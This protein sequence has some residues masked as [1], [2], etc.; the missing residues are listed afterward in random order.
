MRPSFLRTAL[1]GL[2]LAGASAHAQRIAFVDTKY[3]LGQMPDYAA[4]QQELDRTSKKWQDEIDERW[5]Q[6]KRMREAYNAEAIL[7][8]DEMKKSRQAEI[9]KKEQEARDLQQ[10]RFGVGGD[11]FKKRQELIQ[12][13][14]DR[15]YDAVK[16]VAGSSYV[17]IF[18]IGGVGNN[19]LFASEK[20]DKSDNV[21]RKLGIR[22]GQDGKN[23]GNLRGGEEEN[24]QHEEQD[25]KQDD[26]MRT[27]NKGGADRISPDR[28]NQGRDNI[29]T[30]P[31]Q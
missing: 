29:N 23:A 28:M 9:D 13:I 27:P 24:D 17:A 26:R 5:A 3:I 1:M 10:K 18:D 20:Y 30:K 25:M 8:T 12:P 31:K 11:L 4:A 22:P 19:V 6:I 16:E 15:V 7:L 2:L 14:Q 21:L